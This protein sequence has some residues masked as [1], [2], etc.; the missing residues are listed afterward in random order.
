MWYRG[1]NRWETVAILQTVPI[2]FSCGRDVIYDAARASR[3]NNILTYFSLRMPNVS[4]FV[5]TSVRNSL[6]FFILIKGWSTVPD[7]QWYAAR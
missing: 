3:L 7:L 2:G 6:S 4:G 5:A 1:L